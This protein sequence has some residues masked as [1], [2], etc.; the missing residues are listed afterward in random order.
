MRIAR[1]IEGI[2]G[3]LSGVVGLAALGVAFWAPGNTSCTSTTTSD[4]AITQVCRNVSYIAANGI[5]GVL[6]AI[7]GFAIVFV[8][9][10]LGAALHGWRGVREG[11]GMLWVATVLLAFG[12]FLTILDI[13]VFLLPST[14]LAL[15]A[16]VL[17]FAGR[18]RAV[19]LVAS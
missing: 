15:A 5:T 3:V 18:R 4:G 8:V 11:R 2:C 16:S 6:P 17:A 9:I 13:G 19:D 1:T 7:I 14:L 12:T 10:A